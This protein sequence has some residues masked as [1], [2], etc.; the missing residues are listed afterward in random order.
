M[1]KWSVKSVCMKG[2]PHLLDTKRFETLEKVFACSSIQRAI[3]LDLFLVIVT[4]QILL[5]WLFILTQ[6]S[7]FFWKQ[8]QPIHQIWWPP[9]G[10]GVVSLKSATLARIIEASLTGS[11]VI[12]HSRYA[13]IIRSWIIL[14]IFSYN[15]AYICAHIYNIYFSMCCYNANALDEAVAQS[16]CSDVLCTWKFL[17]PSSKLC[18]ILNIANKMIEE[19]VGQADW[20]LDFSILF[21][22]TGDTTTAEPSPLPAYNFPWDVKFT[23]WSKSLWTDCGLYSPSLEK[24]SC[25][26]RGPCPPGNHCFLVAFILFKK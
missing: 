17:P 14:N 15:I 12:F 16:W 6:S 10:V 13:T 24:L 2:A 3:Y 21:W 19:K 5:I 23:V 1:F 8:C 26:H 7:L 9:F 25:S 4:I 18:E 20:C 22:A 11:R